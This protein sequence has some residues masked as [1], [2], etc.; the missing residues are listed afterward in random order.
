MDESQVILS[1]VLVVVLV[2]L[3]VIVV[4]RVVFPPIRPIT[5]EPEQREHIQRANH[6][7]K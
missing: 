7:Q 6:D 2:L 3:V 1:A 4:L 5:I